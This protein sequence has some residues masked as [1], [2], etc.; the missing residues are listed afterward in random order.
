MTARPITVFDVGGTHLRRAS[1]TERHGLAEI[2]RTPSPSRTR[3]PGVAAADLR[4]RLIRAMADQV[5]PDGVAGVS[6]G[7]ALDHH[8][9]T[10]YASAPLWGA[11]TDS[12]DLRAAL[13][14]ARP[15]VRWHVLND[16]TAALLH[17][18][19]GPAARDC[20]K[21]LLTTVS[22]GIAC[23][24]LDRR[25]GE[26][27][28]DGCGLQGEIGHLPST[29][30]LDGVPVELTCDCGV[31]CHLA[32]FSSG[33]GL[34]RLAEFLHTR[35]ARA[36]TRAGRVVAAPGDHRADLVPG[37]ARFAAGG[38]WA[39]GD[40][41]AGITT[42]AQGTSGFDAATVEAASEAA[43]HLAAADHTGSPL[44]EA[45]RT[46]PDRRGPDR[47]G[48]GHSGPNPTG[49]DRTEPDHTAPAQDQEAA[50]FETALSA[51]LDAGDPLAS[52]L[53]AA[54]TRPV[55]DVVRTALCLDPQLDLVAFTGGVAVGLGRHYRAALLAHLA[56]E[57]L[58]ITG[59]RAPR[60]IADRIHVCLP[61]EADGLVG[62][63]LAALAAESGRPLHRLRDGE[64]VRT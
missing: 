40:R 35:G 17:L 20:R 30:L 25:T 2:R 54:A 32:A 11:H 36:G 42:A 31:A 18:A 58:Y 47:M 4:T 61:T 38:P 46:R 56:A 28:V 60:W 51:A 12:F 9:G 3:H 16:V 57:G 33:P 63:G 41:R 14:T 15:D 52:E 59:E 22:T 39:T 26:I 37:S 10:V 21:V 34:R 43:A 23:R 53:L 27:A 44:A 6:L 50:A 19:S 49:S 7:A 5:P 55:A 45:A 62:A 1:W 13:R 64:M 29:L 24:I 48:P 8:T